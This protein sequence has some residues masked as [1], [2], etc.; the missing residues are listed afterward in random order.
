MKNGKNVYHVVS[1]GKNKKNNRFFTRF[2]WLI[3]FVS[4]NIAR[5]D[6]SAKNTYSVSFV[7]ISDHLKF[8]RNKSWVGRHICELSFRE[9]WA[10]RPVLW[11]TVGAH[12]MLWYFSFQTQSDEY[13][14]THFVYLT[15]P[16]QISVFLISSVGYEQGPFFYLT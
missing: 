2:S 1:L 16:F 11:E 13:F 3:I 10:L 5:L 7:K 12:G 15:L 4:R 6:L 8:S 9:N 14:D